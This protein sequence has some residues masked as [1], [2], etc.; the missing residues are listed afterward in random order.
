MEALC[1]THQ[2]THA[3]MGDPDAAAALADAQVVQIIGHTALFFRRTE[4]NRAF[5]DRHAA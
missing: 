1:R 2:P 5:F 3:V 4:H